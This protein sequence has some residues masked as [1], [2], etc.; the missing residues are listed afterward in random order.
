MSTEPLLIVGVAGKARS[1]KDTIARQ[2]VEHY[3]FTRIALADALRE[4]MTGMD[5]QT[6][7]LRKEIEGAGKTSRWALQTLGTECREDLLYSRESLWCLTA[8]SKIR[9]LS[10]YAPIPRRRFVIPDMR[11]PHEPDILAAHAISWGGRYET[12]KVERPGAGL[13]GEAAGHKSETMLDQIL[14]DVYVHNGGTLPMLRAQ[15]SAIAKKKGW[16]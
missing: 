5:G 6:W 9:F 8:L 11:F 15:V 2:L 16:S 10:H 7:E 12:W 13:G 3:G 14:G 1:G 4:I